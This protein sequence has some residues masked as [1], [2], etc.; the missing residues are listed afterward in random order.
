MCNLFK[1]KPAPLK[2]FIPIK[3]FIPK[4]HLTNFY[5]YRDSLGKAPEGQDYSAKLALWR[6]IQSITGQ[7]CSVGQW[8]IKGSILAPYIEREP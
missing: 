5:Q 1:K 3:I 4:E 7:D 8:R 2:I 6:F